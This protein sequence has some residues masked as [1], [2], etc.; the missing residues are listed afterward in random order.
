[1][2]I[3][4]YYDLLPPHCYILLRYFLPF[5]WTLSCVTLWVWKSHPTK[6]W[7]YH[8][9]LLNAFLDPNSWNTAVSAISIDQRNAFRLTVPSQQLS[10]LYVP[11]MS[12]RSPAKMGVITD[13]E[14]QR[15]DSRFQTACAY[16]IPPMRP[17][18]TPHLLCAPTGRDHLCWQPGTRFRIT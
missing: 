8:H 1:M 10:H 7:F 3:P 6:T 14:I 4:P 2:W 5:P 12:P 11:L 15:Q 16:N 9:L 17:L 18:K 13:M